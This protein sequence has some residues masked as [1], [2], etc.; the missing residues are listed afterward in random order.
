MTRREIN[1]N[2]WLY[3]EQLVPLADWAERS[4]RMV[5][6]GCR[7]GA[8]GM[9]TE[10]CVFVQVEVDNSPLPKQYEIQVRSLPSL[11]QMARIV[12]ERMN[13]E[14]QCNTSGKC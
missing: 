2:Y 7:N 8:Y 10:D 14:G 3:V 5:L 13:K 4:A 1:L 12:C 9:P 11:Y 6:A